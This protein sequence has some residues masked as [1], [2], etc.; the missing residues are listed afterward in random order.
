MDI[1]GAEIDALQGAKKIIQKSNPM[2]A[3]CVYHKPNH[4]WKNSTPD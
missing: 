1:E 2:L 3:I 4:L